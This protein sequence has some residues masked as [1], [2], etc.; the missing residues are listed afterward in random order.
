MTQ[1]NIGVVYRTPTEVEEKVLNCK[2]IIEAY[3][4]ALKIFT[5]DSYPEYNRIVAGK[6]RS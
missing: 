5:E 1:N 2:K 3:R 4:E 6:S